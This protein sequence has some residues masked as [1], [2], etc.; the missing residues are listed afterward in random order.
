MVVSWD[1]FTSKDITKAKVDKYNESGI[2]NF[3][4]MVK[5]IKKA[6]E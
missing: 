6:I 3:D 5:G 1:M 2:A 4:A